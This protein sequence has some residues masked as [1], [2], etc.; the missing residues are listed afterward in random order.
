MS[1]IVK[2]QTSCRILLT[3]THLLS[4]HNDTR[5]LSSTPYARNGDQFNKTSE[6]IPI[7]EKTRFLYQYLF[8]LEKSM[9]VIKITGRL[10]GRISEP[11]ERLV[12]LRNPTF[13]QKPPWWLRTEENSYDKGNSRNKSRSQLQTPGNATDILFTKGPL[14]RN[15]SGIKHIYGL[16][17]LQDWHKFPGRYRKQ[18]KPAMTWPNLHE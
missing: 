15:H 4:N 2:S 6:K 17:S 3:A 13:L 16:P 14:A 7:R 9:S 5:S 12:G 8:L 18:S 11:Q 1:A 10:N